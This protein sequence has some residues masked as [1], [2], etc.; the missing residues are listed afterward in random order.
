MIP[1]GLLSVVATAVVF[2]RLLARRAIGARARAT[3]DAFGKSRHDLSLVRALARTDRLAR[4]LATESDPLRAGEAARTLLLGELRARTWILGTIAA[5]APFVGLFG[6]VVGIVRSF[7]AMAT[8][9]SSG[10][11]VVAGGISEALVATG[12]GIVV[13]VF[14]VVASNALGALA[15]RTADALRDRVEELDRGA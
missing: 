14:A 11:A 6:T 5:T 15:S 9:G 3:L 4:V 7:R 12:A 2:E 13:A 1:L 10:F 8:T